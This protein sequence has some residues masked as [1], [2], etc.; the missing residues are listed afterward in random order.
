MRC[1]S[2]G[3]RRPSTRLSGA[4]IA[5]GRRWITLAD[6]LGYRWYRC[7]GAAIDFFFFIRVKKFTSK[8]RER[9]T[10]IRVDPPHLSLT[11]STRLK[12]NVRSRRDRHRC[13]NKKKNPFKFVVRV[14][15]VQIRFPEFYTER[16]RKIPP[17]FRD[18]PMENDMKRCVSRTGTYEVTVDL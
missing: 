18:H 17:F 13:G 14:F 4:L 3:A 11:P 16:Q 1:T 7:Q 12:L 9:R 10:A 6:S 8:A 15:F 2:I 5:A